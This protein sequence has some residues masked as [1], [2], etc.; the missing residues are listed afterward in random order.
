MTMLTLFDNTDMA[1]ITA[2][3]TLDGPMNAKDLA[4]HVP[5]GY[6]TIVKRIP[7]LT[8]IHY[9]VKKPGSGGRYIAN[10]AH[11]EMQHWRDILAAPPYKP[12]VPVSGGV[13]V[14]AEEKGPTDFQVLY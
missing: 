11:P 1:I 14:P 5:I 10:M 13:V 9:L 3:L 2:Y 7:V 4:T 12:P 6:G 8:G